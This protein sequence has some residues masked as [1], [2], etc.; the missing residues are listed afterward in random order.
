MKCQYNA[1]SCLK[2]NFATKLTDARHQWKFN[3]LTGSELSNKSSPVV[4]YYDDNEK[5]IHQCYVLSS[6]EPREDGRFVSALI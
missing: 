3:Q 5:L 6:E 1:Q 2:E 4:A